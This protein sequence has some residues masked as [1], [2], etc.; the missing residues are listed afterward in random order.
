MTLHEAHYLYYSDPVKLEAFTPCLKYNTN[1]T[2]PTNKE[3]CT[4]CETTIVYANEKI[5]PAITLQTS[6]NVRRDM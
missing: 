1:I 6:G 3:H 2:F 4:V 5:F